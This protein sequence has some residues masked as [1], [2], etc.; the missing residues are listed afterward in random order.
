MRPISDDFKSKTREFASR[1][2]AEGWQEEAAVLGS[3]GDDAAWSFL[4]GRVAYL[5]RELRPR[6]SADLRAL[7]DQMVEECRAFRPPDHQGA[8]ERLT[9]LAAQ[10]DDR[11]DGGDRVRINSLLE[12]G[13]LDAK[14][15]RELD[16]Y[17]DIAEERIR[18]ITLL[19]DEE[20]DTGTLR[21]LLRCLS[22]DAESS[23]WT[24]DETITQVI[25]S[26]PP[27]V[28]LEAVLREM[29]RLLANSM[30][31]RHARY[32]VA[33]AWR[34]DRSLPRRVFDKLEP[35]ARAAILSGLSPELASR[36]RDPARDARAG[37]EFFG[38][39]LDL[40]GV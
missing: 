3:L 5:A 28:W 31:R 11:E 25:E 18:I 22:R 13:E 36:W 4:L 27:P 12:D 14:T 29:P 40:A 30:G 7:C 1:L 21:V 38:Y 9:A 35:G 33:R 23:Q 34:V 26:A 8:V 39:L 32:F 17:F 24:F 20:L 10:L 2:A 6:A 15:L 37:S 19:E 16:E